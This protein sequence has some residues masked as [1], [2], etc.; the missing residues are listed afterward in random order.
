MAHAVF[1]A[2]FSEKLF[3]AARACRSEACQ[4]VK[5]VQSIIEKPIESALE[6][7]G[8]LQEQFVPD[9]WVGHRCICSIAPL[10]EREISNIQRRVFRSEEVF[11]EAEIDWTASE[12]CKVS[13]S[14][15]CPFGCPE[16]MR[17]F[18][19]VEGHLTRYTHHL[20]ACGATDRE[21]EYR[22]ACI[23]PVLEKRLQE[24]KE[25]ALCL[26]NKIEGGNSKY[27]FSIHFI[28]NWTWEG[29]KK[30]IDAIAGLKENPRCAP[31]A[32]KQLSS[33][34]FLELMV[35]LQEMQDKQCAPWAEVLLKDLLSTVFDGLSAVLKSKIGHFSDLPNGPERWHEKIEPLQGENHRALSQSFVERVDAIL[36]I[37]EI[38][39]QFQDFP[40]D[41]PVAFFRQLLVVQDRNREIRKKICEDKYRDLVQEIAEPLAREYNPD[42]FL[43][44]LEK[45]IALYD[46]L[47][48]RM[49]CES[50][51]KRISALAVS[52][53]SY[54]FDPF[55]LIIRFSN[56]QINGLDIL[57]DAFYSL[58]S[59]FSGLPDQSLKEIRIQDALLFIS[60][61]GTKE[62]WEKLKNHVQPRNLLCSSEGIEK[63]KA[64]SPEQWVFFSEQEMIIPHSKDYDF[65]LD[66]I[67]NDNKRLF[68]AEIAKCKN[69][70][71]I[72]KGLIEVLSQVYEGE[73]PK[74]GSVSLAEVCA[75]GPLLF[76]YERARLCCGLAQEEIRAEKG[77]DFSGVVR[78]GM[79]EEMAGTV[80]LSVFSIETL[81]VFFRLGPVSKIE[82]W[83]EEEIPDPT[84]ESRRRPRWETVDLSAIGFDNT[85][86]PL[87]PFIDTLRLSR[88]GNNFYFYA[89]EMAERFEEVIQR[90]ALSD[91]PIEPLIRFLGLKSFSETRSWL[92]ETIPDGRRRVDTLRSDQRDA[93]LQRFRRYES[94]LPHLHWMELFGVQEEGVR[95]LCAIEEEE[96]TDYQREWHDFLQKRIDPMDPLSLFLAMG[97]EMGRDPFHPEVIVTL[98]MIAEQKV[99]CGERE[100]F[101]YGYAGESSLCSAQEPVTLRAR[102][103]N[104]PF[105]IA[106]AG[107][108]GFSVAVKTLHR[109]LRE[110][111][112]LTKSL[113]NGDIPLQE[114]PEEAFEIERISYRLQHKYPFIGQNRLF[115]EQN[116]P[117]FGQGGEETP[118]IMVNTDTTP[119]GSAVKR[120]MSTLFA[121]EDLVEMRTLLPLLQETFRTLVRSPVIAQNYVPGHE[122]H[123][124]ALTF[125]SFFLLAR[126]AL[127][128]PL[129]GCVDIRLGANVWFHLGE[130]DPERYE[131]RVE[132]NEGYTKEQF[133]GGHV[134]QYPLHFLSPIS[135]SKLLSPSVFVSFVRFVQGLDASAFSALCA[136]CRELF[137]ED[138]G[139]GTGEYFDVLI[140]HHPEVHF[141]D[142]VRAVLCDIASRYMGSLES[143]IPFPVENGLY[144]FNPSGV[145]D[146]CNADYVPPY[147]RSEGNFASMIGFFFTPCDSILHN[148]NCGINACLVARDG[149]QFASQDEAQEKSREFRR[150]VVQY[151][152]EHIEDLIDSS[153]DREIEQFVRNYE[154]EN[155]LNMVTWSTTLA[156]QCAANL[157]GRP[158]Y[159]YSRADAE[160][161]SLDENARPQPAAILQPNGE[162]TGPPIHLMHWGDNYCA[163]L[164]RE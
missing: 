67:L 3:E 111:P 37:G 10:I 29:N 32:M 35:L 75:Y 148:G 50:E 160:T 137:K 144:H 48:E 64:L 116:Y 130:L 49:V 4:A 28:R 92:Q 112:D 18:F 83:L 122:A 105:Q 6:A 109:K 24:G 87:L 88:L 133:Y 134:S 1:S 43:Y 129:E 57:F 103:D 113:W 110:S 69:L 53:D 157:Y 139:K 11:T 146:F 161:F 141:G 150:E 123:L 20:R 89:A 63:L 34:E 5:R 77:L 46:H 104:R 151:A 152:R 86:W 74:R 132:D 30:V 27:Y 68:F 42:Q 102:Y 58:T 93:I 147:I 82:A 96:L 12:L 59:H 145:G 99:V 162:V 142:D 125:L 80:P 40:I 85:L 14:P 33:E 138:E 100:F 31:D 149:K 118:Q 155:A 23:K 25:S 9:Q 72:H 2:D 126:T 51:R 94:S 124:Q 52:C 119:V 79:F 135:P 16:V 84:D 71:G 101:T 8:R 21:I 91:L 39:E 78:L 45:A 131:E 44:R 163:L 115:T 60:L 81:G 19:D 36:R 97:E 140:Q 22:C 143:E 120:V 41:L 61:G 73:I 107:V 90:V 158:I 136:S 156:W 13:S 55:A 128:R 98:L 56:Q 95:K 70:R 159:V 114:W 65:V 15:F 76:D 153:S 26:K 121:R 17:T 154:R 66:I 47:A 164:P 54:C 117:C 7:L 62:L 106:P 108:F 127:I 38:K